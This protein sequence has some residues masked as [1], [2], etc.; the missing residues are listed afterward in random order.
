MTPSVLMVAA[1]SLGIFVQLVGLAVILWRGG[2]LAGRVESAMTEF[3]GDLERM[4]GRLDKVDEHVSEID[5]RV[6]FIEGFY[7]NGA[8]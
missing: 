6:S 7:R 4:M 1:T 3:R 8:K 5:R 2:H